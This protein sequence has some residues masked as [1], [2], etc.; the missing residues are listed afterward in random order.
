MPHRPD[1][2]TLT[3]INSALAL[4]GSY[5]CR[6]LLIDA[7]SQ[8]SRRSAQSLGLRAIRSGLSETLKAKSE[9][10]LS[11]VPITPTLTLLPAGVPIPIPLAA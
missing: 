7:R 8:A 4:S 3:A 10:K 11:L 9:Q 5:E 1:G 6:A 2:K